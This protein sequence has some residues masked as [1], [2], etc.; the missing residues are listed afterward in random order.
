M[1]TFG[2]SSRTW[3]S[4]A[5]MFIALVPPIFSGCTHSDTV[6][7]LT[8]TAAPNVAEVHHVRLTLSN[9]GAIDVKV[10]PE[11]TVTQAMTFPASLAVVVG[12]SRSGSINV[13]VD[14][15]D[16]AMAVIAH[17]GIAVAIS[18][19]ERTNA[20]V[21]L[22]AG[23]SQCGNA[24]I[25]PG[26]ECDDGNRVSGDGC[27]FMCMLERASDGGAGASGEV[28]DASDS[29]RGDGTT[30]G[31]SNGD[32][33]PVDTRGLGTAGFGGGLDASPDANQIPACS[34]GD[35]KDGVVE[36]V[37]TP[38]KQYPA[39]SQLNCVVDLSDSDPHRPVAGPPC[40]APTQFPGT[41]IF[42]T[43]CSECP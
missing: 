36:D 43:A 26:E 7:A 17:G 40:I 25:D 38:C 10:F 31:G 20:S 19:G 28:T 15:L 42:V 3:T 18:S 13:A 9:A 41:W 32:A 22:L 39:A 5:A 11:A 37:L 6:L 2:R 23:P 27:D 30:S 14:G 4:A 16:A 33:G 24:V 1:S 35:G 21:E 8:L 12:G 34:Y 29:N